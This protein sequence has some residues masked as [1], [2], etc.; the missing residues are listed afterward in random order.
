M[1][2]VKDIEKRKI[3]LMDGDMQ[4]FSMG[5][6][7]DEF[8]WSFKVDFP[9]VIT[10]DMDSLFYDNL[11][12]IM[13]GNYS[14]KNNGLSSLCNGKLIWFSDQMCDF[15]DTEAT[16]RISRLVIEKHDT[17]FKIS[18]VNPFYEEYGINRERMVAFSPMGNGYHTRNML[19]G[20]TFQDDI[21]INLFWNSLNN[22]KNKQYVKKEDSKL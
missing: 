13:S 2:L 22:D 15:E 19:T 5:F 9:V 10:R 1:N 20:S 21:V 7:F 3:S 14:F 4:I 18:M 8:V 12:L 16:D 11:D 6:F 17:F